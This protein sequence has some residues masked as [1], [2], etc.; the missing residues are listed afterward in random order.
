MA[1]FAATGTAYLLPPHTALPDSD[2]KLSFD[3]SPNLDPKN[4]HEYLYLVGKLLAGVAALC[5]IS[6]FV[7]WLCRR[8]IRARR[9]RIGEMMGL[10]TKRDEI[11]RA[12]MGQMG[13]KGKVRKE[14]GK[15]KREDEGREE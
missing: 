7:F 10:G 1:V 12:E 9:R 15:W 5:A 11:M 2:N 3:P 8:R 4:S 13:R 6:I 14:S